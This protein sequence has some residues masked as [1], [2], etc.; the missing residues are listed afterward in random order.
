MLA[1]PAVPALDELTERRYR[2]AIRAY[3]EA[4]PGCDL[5]WIIRRLG[6]VK[7]TARAILVSRFK[8]Y[9]FTDKYRVL[10]ARL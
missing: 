6:S 3:F 10:M 9:A 7:I 5:D 4:E 1:V 8:A 2:N